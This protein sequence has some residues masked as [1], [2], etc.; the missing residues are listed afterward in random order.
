M[1]ERSHRARLAF[2][3]L[4]EFLLGDLQRDNA[5]QPRIARF[6]DFSRAT[7]TEL[8]NDFVGAQSVAGGKRHV[9]K[10]STLLGNSRKTERGAKHFLAGFVVRAAPFALLGNS[11]KTERGAKQFLAGFVVRAAP[12]ALLGNSRK[13]ERGAKHFLA[14]FVVRAAPFAL[15]GNSRKTERGAKQF[16]A[17]FV[18]RA[19]PFALLRPPFS[20]G[21][22]AR[23]DEL[24]NG[25][26]VSLAKF[27]E[28]ITHKFNQLSTLR[29]AIRDGIGNEC[30]PL[31]MTGQNQFARARGSD[32]R[33]FG[34]LEHRVKIRDRGIAKGIVQRV[35]DIA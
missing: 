9:I 34:S 35:W 14:G 3:A 18:V 33:I 19:A 23:L 30:K 26:I 31:W 32:S 24:Q 1:I 28:L 17:G 12:F 16:L 13:T 2:K 10:Q 22:G 11:R 25:G 20:F 29:S 7:G 15:L 21:G 5:I 6:P 4:A 8:R 27:G